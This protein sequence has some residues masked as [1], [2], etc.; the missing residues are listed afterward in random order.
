MQCYMKEIDE[1][2]ADKPLMGEVLVQGCLS[3]SINGL[4]IRRAKMRAILEAKK[5]LL[6]D[7]VTPQLWFALQVLDGTP[8][9]LW[10]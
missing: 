5:L 6:Q 1:F 4:V 8:G 10:R 3:P 7:R 2:D 9:K